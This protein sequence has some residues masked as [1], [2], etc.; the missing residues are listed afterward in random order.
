MIF[1]KA[2]RGRRRG[3]CRGSGH[4]GS[5]GHRLGEDGGDCGAGVDVKRVLGQGRVDG[6]P[7]RQLS[8][9]EGAAE[10]GPQGWVRGIRTLLGAQVGAAGMQGEGRAPRQPWSR[11]QQAR[12][13]RPGP[14]LRRLSLPCSDTFTA[15]HWGLHLPGIPVRG[16][17]LPLGPHSQLCG[18]HQEE[19]STA[20]QTG[21]AW[22]RFSAQKGK[23]RSSRVS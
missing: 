12:R 13:H 17:A 4:V 3:D 20:D 8:A 15:V 22:D 9:V 5:C 2:E 19:T 23:H 14:P 18:P 6:A 16:A 10:H 7:R 21:L 1:I 11:D